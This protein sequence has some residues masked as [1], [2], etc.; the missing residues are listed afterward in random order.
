MPERNYV[1]STIF[2]DDVRTEN[3]GKEIAIGIYPGQLTLP[4]IPF[5]IP[6]LTIRF[7]LFFFGEP[8]ED[9]S[10]R[11]CDPAGTALVEQKRPLIF[12]DWSAPGTLS[13]VIEGLIAPSVGD[14]EI[15]TK[16]SRHDW[17]LQRALV[18]DKYDP[19]RAKSVWQE[20]M[21]RME[22]RMPSTAS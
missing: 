1:Q 3:T 15:F 20:R 14:Y 5:V 12:D 6:V 9:F 11:V 16:T 4:V 21:K 2:C 19:I 8:V 7:E 17:A 10:I 18:I 13:M 22:Q